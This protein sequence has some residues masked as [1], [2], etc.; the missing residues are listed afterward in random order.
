MLI[1]YIAAPKWGLC[2]RVYSEKNF[3]PPQL[4]EDVAQEAALGLDV[5]LLAR[6][7]LMEDR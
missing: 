6:A 5:P 1:S 2:I 3:L 4:P 7:A